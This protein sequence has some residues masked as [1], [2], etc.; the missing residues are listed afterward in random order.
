MK[1][2]RKLFLPGRGYIVLILSG[3]LQ[4]SGFLLMPRGT[5]FLPSLLRRLFNPDFAALLGR[6]RK[7]CEMLIY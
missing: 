1:N 3:F 5:L 7:A 4:I 2:V 6:K